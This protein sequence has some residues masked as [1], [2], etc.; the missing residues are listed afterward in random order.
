MNERAL[1]LVRTVQGLGESECDGGR[2]SAFGA[3]GAV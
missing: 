3:G 2:V 1:S